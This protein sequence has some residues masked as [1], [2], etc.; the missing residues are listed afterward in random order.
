MAGAEADAE[1]AAYLPCFVG[2]PNLSFRVYGRNDRVEEAIPPRRDI[3]GI[4]ILNANL[5]A[6]DSRHP[7]DHPV[8]IR[9]PVGVYGQAVLCFDL[10]SPLFQRANRHQRPNSANYVRSPMSR[11]M[12]LPSLS[13]SQLMC[14]PFPGMP[15]GDCRVIRESQ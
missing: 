5:R 14:G 10:R 13:P 15:A 7:L 11:A 2:C 9:I 6:R 3:H 12:G 4:L 8:G 1:R